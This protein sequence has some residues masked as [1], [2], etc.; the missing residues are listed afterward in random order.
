MV[1]DI[2]NEDESSVFAPT[3]GLP[4]IT[5]NLEK[6]GT[7]IPNYDAIGHVSADNYID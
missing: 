5:Q 4:Y 3:T 7:L 2:E 1:I 6:K